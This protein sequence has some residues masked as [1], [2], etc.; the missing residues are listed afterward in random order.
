[1]NDF[2]ILLQ[3]LSHGWATIKFES[4]EK[5]WSILFLILPLIPYHA[6]NIQR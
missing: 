6:L 3:D 1:M 5:S 2:G 4:H